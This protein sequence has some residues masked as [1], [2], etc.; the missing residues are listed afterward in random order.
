[1]VGMLF[2]DYDELVARHTM[3]WTRYPKDVIPLWVAESDFRTC[4]AVLEAITDAVTRESFGYP[5]DNPGVLAATAEF[6]QDV[7]GFPARPEWVVAVPDVVRGLTIAVDHFT[8]P[9]S[10]VIIPIPAYPPFFQLLQATGREG[11]FVDFTNR[12]DIAAIEAAFAAGA[13]CLVLCNP[14]NPLGFVF[15]E[16]ELKA[17]C[18]AAAKHSARVLVD[19]I[20]APLVY[21]GTH[22]VAAG[23]DETAAKV[24]ITVTATS[25]AWNTAGLKCAQIIFSNESDVRRWDGI[26]GVTKE[27]VSTIGL[28][29]AEA[30]YRHGR[31]FLADE[32]AY[33]KAN[34]DYLIEVLPEAIPGVKIIKPAATYLMWLDLSDTNIPGN[35]AEFLL[36]HAKVAVNDGNWFGE[37]G[38]GCVRVNFATSREI[39]EQA[40]GRIAKAVAGLAA[41][42]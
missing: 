41:A 26:D 37:I 17:V 2:P 36:T 30:A 32:V 31:D 21:D 13:G 12:L 28:V 10:P 1:M 9:G 27:G 20:H 8:A 23:I 29:A 14:F 3:K 7:Y 38:D 22:V 5:P 42:G 11:I 16:A 34:R 4:P 35:K 24:C 19:E 39:L 6:Y 25:K 40:V 33:L 15:S 18:Q